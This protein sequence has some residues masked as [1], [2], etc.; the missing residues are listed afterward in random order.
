MVIFVECPFLTIPSSGWAG[1]KSDSDSECGGCSSGHE[2]WSP[3][4]SMEELTCPICLVSSTPS[5]T[6]G[7]EEKQDDPHQSDGSVLPSSLDGTTITTAAATTEYKERPEERPILFVQTPCNHIFCQSC[8]EHV[9]LQPPRQQQHHQQR[10]PLTRGPCPMCR[11]SISLFDL[12]LLP[13]THVITVGVETSATTI[14]KKIDSGNEERL[15]FRSDSNVQSWPSKSVF[16]SF[17]LC[18]YDVHFS[19]G[20][21]TSCLAFFDDGYIQK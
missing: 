16:P 10:M 9:L 20:Y 6:G 1:N 18:S 13:P 8:I 7:N 12:R 19:C 5:S 4:S 17:L 21:L 3:S 14:E 2:C 11:V 15:V